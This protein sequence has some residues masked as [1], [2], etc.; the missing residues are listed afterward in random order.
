MLLCISEFYVVFLLVPQRE[1]H[2]NREV[3]KTDPTLRARP[4]WKRT[5]TERVLPTEEH[6]RVSLQIILQR[7]FPGD[8]LRSIKQSAMCQTAEER[9]TH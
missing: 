9:G 2:F 3:W 8:L 4:L 1:G 7:F 5:Q 6:E